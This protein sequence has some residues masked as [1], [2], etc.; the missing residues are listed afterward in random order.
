M[1][2]DLPQTTNIG[3][4]KI[5]KSAGRVKVDENVIR[6]HLEVLWHSAVSQKLNIFGVFGHSR[7]NP[8]NNNLDKFFK[9]NITLSSVLTKQMLYHGSLRNPFCRPFSCVE[10]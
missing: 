10:V 9:L 8:H 3:S 1:K 2:V 6:L 5:Q 7:L 4:F